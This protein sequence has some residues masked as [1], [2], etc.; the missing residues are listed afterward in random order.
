[1]WR[2]YTV[3]INRDGNLVLVGAT[4]VSWEDAEFTAR[5]VDVGQSG[6]GI[7]SRMSESHVFRPG[8]YQSLRRTDMRAQ[9][10]Q[11]CRLHLDSGQHSCGVW[12]YKS[13]VRVQHEYLSSTFWR[14]SYGNDTTIEVLCGVRIYGVVLE[15]E[16]GYR[17]SN[18]DVEAMFVPGVPDVYVPVDDATLKP[19]YG[20]GAQSNVAVFTAIP[21][22]YTFRR[23][24]PARVWAKLADTYKASQ[25]IPVADGQEF[26]A[27]LEHDYPDPWLRALVPKVSDEYA[28]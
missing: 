4:G 12:G 11:R 9:E 10:Y 28:E 17:A 13:P 23:L 24:D 19:R 8:E 16:H 22:Y 7:S 15:G 14:G 3:G 5:C 18:V 6:S 26:I 1:M 21:P 2:A 20:Y 27:M 25:V